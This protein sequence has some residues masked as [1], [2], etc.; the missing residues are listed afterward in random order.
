MHPY[1]YFPSLAQSARA[2]EYTDCISAGGMTPPTS[3]LDMP[4]KNLMARP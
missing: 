2:V 1:F 4:P 3:V